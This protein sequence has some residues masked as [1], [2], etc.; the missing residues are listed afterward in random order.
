MV[1]PAATVTA[2]ASARVK[3]TEYVVISNA[4]SANTFTSTGLLPSVIANVL[5]V[6]AVPL[7]VIESTVAKLSV[8]T[9]ARVTSLTGLGTVAV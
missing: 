1:A 9:V 5:P 3:V 6:T 2:I 4:S 8:K 7:A